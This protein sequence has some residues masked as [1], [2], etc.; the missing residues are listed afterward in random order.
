MSL[1]PPQSGSP[2]WHK[3]IVLGPYAPASPFSGPEVLVSGLP[4][5]ATAATWST[6]PGGS[7]LV[8]P[9][10][11]RMSSP[12][13]GTGTPGMSGKEGRPAGIPGTPGMAGTLG[14]APTRKSTTA[15]PSEKPPSTNRVSGQLAIS[16]FPLKEP[17][18]R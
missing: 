16:G 2:A 1:P 10:P 17:D 11:E 5:T 14:T 6:A 7:G 4:N 3:S 13:S 12:G 18:A 15:A 8:G 9:V